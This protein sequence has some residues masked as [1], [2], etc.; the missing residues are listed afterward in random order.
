MELPIKVLDG[1]EHFRV[2]CPVVTFLSRRAET[3]VNRRSLHFHPQSKRSG[4]PGS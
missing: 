4:S 1:T 3:S 2:T